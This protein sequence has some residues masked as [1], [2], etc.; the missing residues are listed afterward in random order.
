MQ[1]VLKCV[2]EDSCF[3]GVCRK[4]R[5]GVWLMDGLQIAMRRLKKEE[6]LFSSVRIVVQE[7][8]CIC[9]FRSVDTNQYCASELRFKLRNQFEDK[10][11]SNKF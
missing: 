5:F 10:T 11:K 9:F 7:S 6:R 8:G 3:S 1:V 4:R 2:E